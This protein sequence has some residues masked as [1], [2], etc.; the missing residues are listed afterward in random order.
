MLWHECCSSYKRIFNVS[1]GGVERAPLVTVQTERRSPA[2]IIFTLQHDRQQVGATGSAGSV[3]AGQW[4]KLTQWAACSAI[5][6]NRSMSAMAPFVSNDVHGLSVQESAFQTEVESKARE[7]RGG[8]P[9]PNPPAR[10]SWE[11]K[12]PR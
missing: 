10:L 3:R 8:F 11:S 5:F 6:R 7:W 12:I 9:S 2:T 1:G 4:S